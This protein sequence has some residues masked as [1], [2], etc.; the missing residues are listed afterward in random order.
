MWLYRGV[1][2]ALIIFISIGM[3]KILY[4]EDTENNRILIRRRLEA[5]GYVVMTAEDAEQGLALAAEQMP[6]LILM[7][8]SLP[9]MD[10]WEATQR[11]KENPKT[12]QIPIIALTAH[13]MP[14]DRER[15]MQAGCDDYDTKPFQF[16]R[17]LAK[18]EVLLELSRSPLPP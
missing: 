5:D 4:I 15:S 18:M 12:K 7:D 9:G 3:R 11:L 8:L 17:L 6:D 16:A 2:S 10:G 14:G 13:V 1:D